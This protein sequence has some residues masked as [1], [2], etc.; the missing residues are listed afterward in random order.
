MLVTIKRKETDREAQRMEHLMFDSRQQDIQLLSLSRNGTWAEISMTS[1][2][3][4]N[5]YETIYFYTKNYQMS[6]LGV[7]CIYLQ[8]YR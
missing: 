5:I 4:E 6:L 3:P 2:R 1:N 7:R 8:I